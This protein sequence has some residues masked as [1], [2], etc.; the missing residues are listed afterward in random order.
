MTGVQSL[1][2]QID[3]LDVEG[4]QT[5]KSTSF[6]KIKSFQEEI[7]ES[8][9]KDLVQ[10]INESPSSKF[11]VQFTSNEDQYLS[12]LEKNPK[13]QIAKL[14]LEINLSADHEI[15]NIFTR[16]Q[17]QT[18]FQHQTND[19][20]VIKNE[21]ENVPE[22]KVPPNMPLPNM[23]TQNFQEEPQ[24]MPEPEKSFFQKYF[25]YIMIGGFLVMQLLTVDK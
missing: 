17:T 20:K 16:K 25:W 1:N 12:F 3:L 8:D 24:K 6:L 10:K 11:V 15:L 2:F 22:I 14:L 5:L 19:I 7:Y 13:E 4:Q 18:Q 23:N 21:E 9:L